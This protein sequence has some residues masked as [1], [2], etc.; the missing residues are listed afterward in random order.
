MQSIR[1]GADR[2]VELISAK[3]RI[4]LADAAKQ[5]GVGKDVIHEWAESLE[6]EGLIIIKYSFSKT[7]L[8]EK[9]ITKGE[10][11]ISGK[12]AVSE[13]DAFVRKIDIAL[14]ALDTDAAGFEE[15]RRHFLNIQSHIKNEIEA[16]KKELDE[17]ERF[18]LLKKNLDKDIEA[19]QKRYDQ[20]IKSYLSEIKGEE[21]KYNDLLQLIDKEQKNLGVYRQKYS[22]IKSIRAESEQILKQ[23][24][25]SINTVQ[26]ELEKSNSTVQFYEKRLQELESHATSLAQEIAKKKEKLVADAVKAVKA[27][28][29]K[30]IAEQE[31]LLSAVRERSARM[32]QYSDVSKKISAD[33]NGFFLKT[34]A[35][36]K[37]IGEL[38]KERADI[39]NSYKILK[40]KLDKLFAMEHRAGMTAE[41]KTI[42][43][44]LK[45][46]DTKRSTFKTHIEKLLELVKGVRTS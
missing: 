34:I 39:E 43:K 31:K 37:M 24:Q 32:N 11:S 29:D 38:Q 27:D 8:E 13:R 35:A 16:V 18:D 45:L 23:A 28:S 41:L 25:T 12:E 4:E 33:F 21:D 14:T 7:W 5:L 20:I 26:K 19:Q 44:E 10:L 9:Q 6:Q 17:L 30:T 42:E 15:L 46:L 1:T 3:K 2:L 22:E 40:Q 36:D